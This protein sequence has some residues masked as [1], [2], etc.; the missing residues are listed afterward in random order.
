MRWQFP[1]AQVLVVD[2]GVENRQ[3]V[4][5]LLE[6]T[7]LRVT[8]AENGQVALDLV[9]ASPPDLVLMDMQMPV[10]DGKTA[11]RRLREQGYTLPVIALTANAMKGFEAEIERSGFSGFLTKPIDVDLLLAELAQRLGGQAVDTTPITAPDAAQAPLPE[12]ATV[13]A[14]TNDRPAEVIVSRLAS[15][16]KLKRIIGRFVEQLPGKIAQM[17]AAAEKGDMVD[18]EG[19]AHWLKGAGGS[20]GFD[21]FFEPAKLLE[22]AAQAGDREQVA[23]ALATIR[24]LEAGILRG[25]EARLSES[26]EASS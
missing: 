17:D 15:H 25:A 7:G 19:L 10:M 12:P 4:R 24:R 20:M 9:A 26:M 5:V 13:D 1:P 6:E 22:A 21:G 2:D 3:L 16:P 8:E 11:T 14:A 18:L 23:V